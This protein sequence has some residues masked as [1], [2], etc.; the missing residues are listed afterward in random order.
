MITQQSLDFLK[1]LSKN[2]NRDWY[3]ENKKRYEKELKKPFEKL[4]DSIISKVQKID[5]EV[6]VPAKKSIFRIYRDTRFS[7]DKSP[8]KTHVSAVIAPGGTKNKEYPGFYMHVEPGMLMMGGG[9][10]FLET[11]S[12]YQVRQFISQNLERFNE[13]VTDTN[14][15]AKYEAIKGE[16]NKRLPK[17]FME[18]AEQQ[19]LLY[20]KQFYYMA[21]LPPADVLRDDF[22][23]YALEY[24]RAAKPVKDFLKEA[25]GL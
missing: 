21:E 12:L 23:D 1:D 3:H 15:V 13:L 6:D 24:Y 14:F 4:V 2:N 11:A 22:I 20:N 25:L 16:Q 8:Y 18:A 9:A 5:P 7:K 10:Y 19:P 17:E